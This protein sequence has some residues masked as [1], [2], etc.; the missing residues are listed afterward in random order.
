MKKELRI[1]GLEA[2]FVLGNN[3]SEKLK[4]RPVI[5]NIALRFSGDNAACLSDELKDTVCYSNLAN[6]IGLNLKDKNFNLIEHAVQFVYQL[7]DKHLNNIGILKRVEAVKIATEGK[8][9]NSASFI[10]SDW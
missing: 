3:E 9:L 1:N 8:G 7:I 10:L 2:H 4:A 6:V 5:L